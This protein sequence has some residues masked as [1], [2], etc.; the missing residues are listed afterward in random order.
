MV[1]DTD[2]HWLAL[3]IMDESAES[4]VSAVA[5]GQ[6]QRLKS[7]QGLPR[8]TLGTIKVRLHS[9]KKTGWSWLSV[10]TGAWFTPTMSLLAPKSTLPVLWM[11]WVHFSRFTRNQDRTGMYL[12]RY[13]YYK[14]ELKYIKCIFSNVIK[15]CLFFLFKFIV[16]YINAYLLPS[17]FLL[18]SILR[19]LLV[20]TTTTTIS[21]G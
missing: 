16:I 4:A 14:K 17:F 12:M 21:T 19:F 2:L 1:T 13:F 20:L 9:W 15:Q 3:I 10:T 11:S 7:T 5:R 6:A 18:R 8:G